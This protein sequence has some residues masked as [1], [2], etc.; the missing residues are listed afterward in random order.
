LCYVTGGLHDIETV[1]IIPVDLNSFLYRDAF[2]LANFYE[3]LGNLEKSQYYDGVAE[4]WKA[5][6][7]AVHWNEGI[8]TWLDYDTLNNISRNYFYPSNL[9]PLWTLCYNAVRSTM[10]RTTQWKRIHRTYI[11]IKIHNL[12]N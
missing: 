2:L 7:T 8:G 4:Q 5:A 12:Q 3:K 10:N 11:T 9:A 1:N 6:V